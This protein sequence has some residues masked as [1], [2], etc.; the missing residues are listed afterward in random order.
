MLREPFELRRTATLIASLP[1]SLEA[2]RDAIPTLPMIVERIAKE[3]R[4]EDLGE[5]ALD[6][7][8]L[9]ATQIAELIS[10]R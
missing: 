8:T 2:S 4:R 5:A 10:L 7:S 3:R 1:P 6:N 9:S